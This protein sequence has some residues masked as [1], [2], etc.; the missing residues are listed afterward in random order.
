MHVSIFYTAYTP[1]AK[2]SLID[3]IGYIKFCD[4]TGVPLYRP[5]A[6]IISVIIQEFIRK[7]LELIFI[8]S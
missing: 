5:M 6:I 4:A 8:K 7:K 2:I 3:D 1:W